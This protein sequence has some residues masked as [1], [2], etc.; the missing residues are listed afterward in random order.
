[1]CRAVGASGWCRH[2]LLTWE[3][4]TLG[5]GVGNREALWCRKGRQNRDLDIAPPKR[6]SVMTT[7]KNTRRAL[8][9]LAGSAAAV[10]ALTVGSG[11]ANAAYSTVE[12][13]TGVAGS[14]THTPGL[15]NTKARTDTAVL[16]GTLSGC[17]GING[18]QAGT[19]T[20][21]II[22]SGKATADA[23]TETGTVTVNWPAS[24][25]LN[26]SNGTVT[27][28]LNGAGVP[29]AVSGSFTSGAFTGAVLSTDL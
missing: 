24:S 18:A 2:H 16:T 10:A 22:A 5:T 4:H 13:C 12:G 26:P 29:I 1:M 14:I 15:L 27:L 3:A 21:T 20:V 19:G 6:K 9:L 17:S 8:A 11:A 28:R 25:G 23:Y 7:T